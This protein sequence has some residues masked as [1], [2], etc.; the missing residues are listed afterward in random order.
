MCTVAR[1]QQFA[2]QHY[3]ANPAVL[4]QLFSSLANRQLMTVETFLDSMER[5]PKLANFV[6]EIAHYIKQ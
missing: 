2:I 3:V 6:A 1:I 4:P 5:N